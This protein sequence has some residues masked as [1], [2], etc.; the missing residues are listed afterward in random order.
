MIDKFPYGKAPFWILAI[1]ILSG[2]Y[3]TFVRYEKEQQ[4]PDLVFSL[5]SAVHMDAYRKILPD[6]EKKHNVKVKLE[7]VNAQAL[8][9]RLQNAMLAGA[10]VPDM[11]ELV[12]N[13]IGFFS[14]GPLEDIMFVDLTDRIKAE[15]LDTSVVFSRYSLWSSR[16][17]IF[18]LPHDVHPV[19]LAYRRDIVE[20]L[21]IEVDS[22]DTWEEF[23]EMGRRITRD[24]DGDGV[25]DRYALQLSDGYNALKIL[26]LQRGV[27][28]FDSLGRARFDDPRTVEVMKWYIDALHGENSFAYSISKGQMESKLLSDGFVLFHLTPDWKSKNFERSV[29]NLEGKMALMPLPAWEEGGRR[30]STQ[31]GTGL[32]ITEQCENKELAW[33]LAKYLYFSEKNAGRM[34]KAL[35]ILPP[36]KELWDL[37]EFN[38]PNSYYSG[39]KIGRLYARLA[40]Q[41]PPYYATPYS[42]L[43]EAKIN[44]AYTRAVLRYKSGGIEALNSFLPTE[45]DRQI[46]RVRKI[47]DY[48]A[49]LKAEN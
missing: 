46:A 26:L 19:M 47:M 23:A 16:T 11:V 17:R 6:F 30:T 12:E 37:P 45:L 38:K 5:F 35:N 39:Q 32:A 2:L 15:G 4:K 40:P 48:N 24:V 7:L 28:F 25:V 29:P 21:G 31:G 3:L 43:A 18:A 36:K 33:K 27:Q 9:G 42:S 49:F 34:F 8:Q 41:A 1:S 10:E 20:K 22:I 13:S 14:K 44:E